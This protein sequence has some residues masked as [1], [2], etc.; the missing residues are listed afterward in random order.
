MNGSNHILV[1]ILEIAVASNMPNNP[2][3]F[4]KT[5]D[6]IRLIAEVTK[7]TYFVFLKIPVVSRYNETVLIVPGITKFNTI[8]ISVLKSS[9]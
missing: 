3:I 5:M 1:K 7:N 9:K 8:T 2:H 4:P 6:K